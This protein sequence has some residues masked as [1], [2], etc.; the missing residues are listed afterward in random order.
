MAD[1]RLGRWQDVLADVECDALISDPPYSEKTHDGHGDGIPPSAAARGGYV[2][3]NGGVDRPYE[4][5]PINYAAF[6]AEDVSEF[7][8]HWTPRTKGWI[9]LMTDDKL[10]PV[11]SDALREQGRYVFAPLPF[12]A[13]GSRVRLSGDGPSS[14]TVWIVVA[15]PRCAPYSNWGTLPGAYVLPKGYTE[16][17]PVVGGKQTW[18]MQALIRDYSRPGDLI[19]DPCAGAGTTLLAAEREHRRAIGAEMDPE[20]HAIAVERLSLPVQAGLF[21]GAV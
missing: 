11:W 20:H 17:Q 13:P 10:A 12:V 2:R 16:R 19:C 6:T 1:L 3:Q 21:K 15:R 7:C 14:W 4:R 8:A 18:I 9:V 5:R